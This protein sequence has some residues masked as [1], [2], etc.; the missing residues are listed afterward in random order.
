M[1]FGVYQR[2]SLGQF[3]QI[4]ALQRDGRIHAFAE[5]DYRP[6]STA[7]LWLT[8]EVRRIAQRIADERD[9]F[10]RRTVRAAPR[11]VV[12]PPTAAPTDGPMEEPVEVT[13]R[14]A[15]EPP[16]AEVARPA[17][18]DAIRERIRRAM[19]EGSAETDV[20]AGDA[21]EIEPR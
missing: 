18:A 10:L 13:P 6:D 5:A 19:D 14:A 2:G 8:T 15:A 1:T 12:E 17:D 9:A 11:H 20:E 16:R 3:E 21:L 4:S 7:H